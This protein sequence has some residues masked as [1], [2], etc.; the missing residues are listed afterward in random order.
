MFSSEHPLNYIER[1]RNFLKTRHYIRYDDTDFQRLDMTH[2]VLQEYR[3]ECGDSMCVIFYT[4]RHADDAYIVPVHILDKIFTPDNFWPEVGENADRDRRRWR[5]KI[6]GDRL[7]V[8]RK[9]GSGMPAAHVDLDEFHN[10]YELLGPECH[11]WEPFPPKESRV[12]TRPILNR[13]F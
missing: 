7:I 1:N 10:N 12:A 6:E 2:N 8:V 4:D 5:L 11:A 9:A 3:E 13:L